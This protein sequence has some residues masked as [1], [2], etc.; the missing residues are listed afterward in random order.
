M[1]PKNP[2]ALDWSKF[3]VPKGEEN[4][5]HLN[6]YTIKS[7]KLKSTDDKLV[8]LS[9]MKGLTIIY[10]FPTT[11]QPDKP[12]PDNWDNIPG[13]RGCTPQICSF[14]DNFN[15]LKKLNVDNIF[16]LSTQNNEDQKEL[17][18][19]LNLPYQILSDEKLEFSS[20]LKL[21]IFEVE[22][23]KLI[24]R[25]TLILSNNKIIKYFYPVFPPDKNV[26]DVIKF[27]VNK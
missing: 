16:G 8:E 15:Q 7:V 19:R 21:P 17:V 23:M 10:I 22:D 27:L 1:N 11:G 6:N 9:M 12:M 14:R 18:K 5:S 3:P 26:N 4:L 24:K 25:I 13:A 20:Q 2:D